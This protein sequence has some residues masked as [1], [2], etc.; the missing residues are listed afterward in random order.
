MAVK[1]P[2]VTRSDDWDFPANKYPNI[3]WLGRVHRG[4]P[5]Q[6]VFLKSTNT[7]QVVG[8]PK[9]FTQS[10][11]NWQLWS[12]NP[13][14]IGNPVLTNMVSSNLVV[15]LVG[16]NVN[17]R[18]PDAVFSSPTNDWNILD[19]FT[20]AFNDNAGRGQL[21]VN[22][23]NLAAW[24]AVL[25]GVSVLPNLTATNP[26][27]F[28]LPS[29][30]DSLARVQ[31][32]VNG[33]NNT[34]TNFPNNAFPRMGD[35]LATPELTIASPYLLSTNR[36]QI[37]NDAVVERIPQQILGLLHGGE[38]PPR[39]V[40]YSY[41][42]ALKPAPKSFVMT[43]GPYF[44]MCTNYTITAEV[45]TRAVVHIEGAPNKPRTVVESYNVLPPD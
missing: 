36:A 5:W 37:I 21:S 25:G 4:T 22:Q 28:I 2:S 33:I 7:M 10:L 11:L 23:T 41:G 17:A 35:V 16:T 9:G 15:S 1:D 38:Q 43:S 14:T 32:I 34:R 30:A 20:T 18:L 42:Q 27:T 19:L 8:G 26:P 44:G 6:T 29:G 45:A 39:F 13:V 24:S 40:I 31:K 3:G 12:G